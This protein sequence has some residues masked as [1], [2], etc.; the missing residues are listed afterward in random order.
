MRPAKKNRQLALRHQSGNHGSGGVP[1]RRR[2]ERAKS[3]RLGPHDE[4][5]D[6]VPE[7]GVRITGAH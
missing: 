4:R 5:A 2:Y 1:R 7:R 6:R 3:A